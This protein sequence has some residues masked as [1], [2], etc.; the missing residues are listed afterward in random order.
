MKTLSVGELKAH[1]SEVLAEIRAGHDVAIAYGRKKET[2]AV[3]VP[4]SHYSPTT[5]KLGLFKNKAKVK[6]GRNFKMSDTEFLR[7]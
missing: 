6:F 2:L 5:R 7:S 4:Y 3:I 1:F